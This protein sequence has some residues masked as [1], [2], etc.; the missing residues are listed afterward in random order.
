MR[1]FLPSQHTFSWLFD[2]T[3]RE[4][5]TTAK[6]FLPRSL[7]EA[8]HRCFASGRECRGDRLVKDN[9]AERFAG[10]EKAASNSVI[11]WCAK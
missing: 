7:N 3:K 9:A 4:L 11:C 10:L 6:R 8:T 2:E 5:W 1:N